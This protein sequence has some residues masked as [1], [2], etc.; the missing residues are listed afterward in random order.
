MTI[1]NRL[2]EV[3]D[4]KKM[5]QEAFGAVAGVK[6][7]AQFRYEK[8][9]RYPDGLYFENIA[10]IGCDVQYIITGEPSSAKLSDDETK[11]LE[12]FRKADLQLKAASMAVLES[13]LTV[14]ASKSVNNSGVYTEGDL[15]INS[16]NFNN[17]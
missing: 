3:R 6:Q 9:E 11:M 15:K 5:S 10:K 1:G 8:G 13:G 2:K 7:Q 16:D 12:L 4:A 17:K 14:N